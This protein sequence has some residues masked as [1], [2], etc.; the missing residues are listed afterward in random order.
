MNAFPSYAC[1]VLP[2]DYK[3]QLELAI[4]STGERNVYNLTGRAS[5]PLSEG[6]IVIEC[7]VRR[8][9]MGSNA[10]GCKG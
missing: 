7:Q 3:G 9:D 5:E 6:H 8:M 1:H 10:L 4:P 2:G